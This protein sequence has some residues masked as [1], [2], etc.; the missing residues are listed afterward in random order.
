MKDQDERRHGNVALD[1]RRS[2]SGRGRAV[3]AA[4]A[5]TGLRASELCDLRLRDLR[6]HD[7]TGSRLRVADAKTEAGV[8]AVQLSL[9]VVE[10]LVSHI[11]RLRRAGLPVDP[12]AYVFPNARGR[13]ISRQRVGEIVRDAARLATERLVDR[14]LPPLP[15]TTPHSLRR[16][17]VTIALLANNFDAMWVMSQV[18]HAD[19]KMTMDVYAQLQQRVPCDHGRWPRPACP[20]APLRRRDRPHW[21]TDWA[22]RPG[23]AGSDPLDRPPPRTTKGHD[24]Q[25]LSGMARP[26]LEPGTPR[27]SGRELRCS[28]C[29]EIPADELVWSGC[30]T[31]GMDVDCVRL[32]AVWASDARSGPNRREPSRRA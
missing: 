1:L 22:T 13:R 4:L 9:D 14:G 12:D 20:R 11:D 30:R 26:G 16:T 25:A 29:K 32:C 18:G 6:L 7:A 8:R 15:N 23:S 17:Y 19:S 27:F 3:V 5:G 24:L 2:A 21:A 31:R 10:E 28:N